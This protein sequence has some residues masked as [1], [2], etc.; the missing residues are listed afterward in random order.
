MDTT[1]A[2]A[3]GT[4]VA[5]GAG[6]IIFWLIA[7]ILGLILFIWALV[8]VIRRQ[9]PNPNDKILWI[10]LIIIIGWIGP[11]LYLIIG[12]KKGHLP[13]AKAASQQ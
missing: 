9:F 11:L 12:R 4:A 3:A 5:I 1:S 8:D 13:G 10:I 6:L 2:A 7:G